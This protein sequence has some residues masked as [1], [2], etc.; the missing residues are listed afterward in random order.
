MAKS[1]RR[2]R[3]DFKGVDEQGRLE[4]LGGTPSFGSLSKPYIER[5][6][7]L[8]E[9]PSASVQVLALERFK[10]VSDLIEQARQAMYDY[11]EDDEENE[12]EWGEYFRVDGVKYSEEHLEA[13][14]QALA[15]RSDRQLIPLLKKLCRSANEKIRA[16]AALLLGKV[17]TWGDGGSPEEIRDLLLELWND[18][19]LEVHRG[20]T[21]GL[22]AWYDTDVQAFLAE[23]LST[24]PKERRMSAFMILA[25]VFDD[26]LATGPIELFLEALESEDRALQEKAITILAYYDRVDER[27]IEP[28]VRFF[29]HHDFDEDLVGGSLFAQGEGALEAL[30]RALSDPQV[31]VRAR[32]ASLLHFYTAMNMEE[33]DFAIPESLWLEAMQFPSLRTYAFRALA[34]VPSGVDRLLGFLG[35][36]KEEKELELLLEVLSEID[37]ADPKVLSAIQE[38]L[39]SWPKALRLEGLEFFYSEESEER[40]REAWGL[41]SRLAREDEASEVRVEALNLLIRFGASEIASALVFEQLEAGHLDAAGVRALS[42]MEIADPSMIPAL[43][44]FLM[45][46]DVW[47]ST[48][49]S[50]AAVA[51]GKTKDLSVISILLDFL[52]QRENEYLPDLLGSALAP[53]GD[54]AVSA[55]REVWQAKSLHPRLVE[56]IAN[57]LASLGTMA[58]L[59]CLLLGLRSRRK[60][61]RVAAANSLEVWPSEEEDTLKSEK[62]RDAAKDKAVSTFRE[63]L[64]NERSQ[65][66][67]RSLLSAIGS[68]GHHVRETAPLLR[69]MLEQK[70][71]ETLRHV[72][73]DTLGR[74]GD[75]DSVPALI[76]ALA[77]EDEAD[78]TEALEALKKIGLGAREAIPAVVALVNRGILWLEREDSLEE[79]LGNQE[80][81]WLESEEAEDAWEERN[82]FDW[83]GVVESAVEFLG[84]CAAEELHPLVVRIFAIPDQEYLRHACALALYRLQTPYPALAPTL[85]SEYRL[86]G[87]EDSYSAGPLCSLVGLWGLK[88]A[89]EITLR[90]LDYVVEQDEWGAWSMLRGL[91]GV[92][93]P[94]SLPSL[95]RALEKDNDDGLLW[96]ILRI[97][98]RIEGVETAVWKDV[99]KTVETLFVRLEQE[100][101]LSKQ[102]EDS[103]DEED[104]EGLAYIFRLWFLF[105]AVFGE[106]G[107]VTWTQEAHMRF[108]QGA[109]Q[110]LQGFQDIKTGEC[111]YFVEPDGDD[112]TQVDIYLYLRELCEDIERGLA[113]WLRALGAGAAG[114]HKQEMIQGV[115]PVIQGMRSFLRG[116]E[117]AF[118]DIPQ[119]PRV[120]VGRLLGVLEQFEEFSL[121]DT[122]SAYHKQSEDVLFHD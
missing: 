105:Y 18:S 108:L 78:L 11:D 110:L 66:A 60:E 58:S 107:L 24:A 23:Q 119:A 17:Y 95:L 1:Q 43:R 53:M 51:L 109:Q 7:L 14:F 8:M 73:F 46:G 3:E 84:I 96:M 69:K 28:M 115:W 59:E 103:E 113:M 90:L 25:S 91:A 83:S 80:A 81:S 15:R 63:R 26:S 37:N 104:S 20:A 71:Y 19:S 102:E 44:R 27:L 21:E 94:A 31:E 68:W 9:D 87:P 89:E 52:V 42:E 30:T 64:K 92:C 98:A 10:Q 99:H 54:V 106:K 39:L 67:Q 41:L 93:S 38:H 88:E 47:D 72:L 85:L 12:E 56:P 75:V 13:L 33:R 120:A 79:W 61:T 22:M 49:L 29:L 121:Q 5:L 82:W 70:K 118:F 116:E 50:Y 117:E 76:L 86:L 6:R 97:F 65:D 48:D 112:A 74:L 55:L 57:A 100:A 32:A 40:Q 62:M 34:R 122:L 114:E 16:S 101:L 45:D 2:K 36:A 35:H 4:A 77:S 111:F